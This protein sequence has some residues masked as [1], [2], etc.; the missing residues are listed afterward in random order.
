[1]HRANLFVATAV[2]LVAV[3]CGNDTTVGDSGPGGAG[4][5]STGSGGVGGWQ[6]LVDASWDVA[7]GSE[8]YMCALT[9]VKE[10][11]YIKAFRAIAPPGTH[12]TVVV[13]TDTDQPDG[14]FA[15]SV[16]TLS[17]Q[18]IFGSGV[19]TDEL[20]FPDGVAMKIPAGRKVLVNLHLFNANAS[21]LQGVSGTEIQTIPAAD[22][23]QEAEVVM[24]TTLDIDIPPM[25]IGSATARCT[26]GADSTVMTI[27]PHMHQYGRHMTVSHESAGGD[28]VLHDGAFDFNEQLNY[29]IDPVM[30][31]AGE[32]VR[33]D[34][35][36]ENTSAQTVNWGDSSLAEMCIA[37]VYRYP[38]IQGQVLCT[39]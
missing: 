27:F 28:V 39:Q 24:A 30:V 20:V 34:C 9:T 25:Q 19:G 29:R 2:L 1:M 35:S 10:D 5:S 11:T 7:S 13:V 12:H 17:D 21:E 38:S 14:V 18:M 36:Y 23:Q 16:S 26:F 37:G 31:R 4:G 32:A 6:T 22:V 8:T 15:C 33:A 3:G